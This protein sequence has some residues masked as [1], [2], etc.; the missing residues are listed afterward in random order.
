MLAAR[1][2]YFTK[3]ILVILFFVATPSLSA[4]PQK[5]TVIAI[6]SSHLPSHLRAGAGGSPALNAIFDQGD[7]LSVEHATGDG[8]RVSVADEKKGSGHRNLLELAA[9]VMP[10]PGSEK[11]SAPEA[12]ESSKSTDPATMPAAGMV[13]P[14]KESPNPPAAPAPIGREEPQHDSQAKSQSILQMIEGHES[15][16]KYGLIIVAT[17]FVLGWL[18]GGAYYARRERRA[19]HKLRF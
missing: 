6:V 1:Q 16:V 17:T 9:A 8:Y 14:T 7:Q 13:S 19:R 12:E 11:V 4:A 15:E 10:P 18:C 5:A 2:I 3:I